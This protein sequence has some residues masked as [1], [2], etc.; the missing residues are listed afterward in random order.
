MKNI[1][2]IIV[3]FLFFGFSG[4]SSAPNSSQSTAGNLVGSAPF[5]GNFSG[6]SGDGFT[7]MVFSGNNLEIKLN[8]VSSARGKFTFS[9]NKL[10]WNLTHAYV[11]RKRSMA[12]TGVFEAMVIF[13]NRYRWIKIPGKT[14]T[15]WNYRL[16]GDNLLLSDYE[17]VATILG[18]SNSVSVSG[19][20]PPLTRGAPVADA[21]KIWARTPP[22]AITIA[23]GYK[24]YGGNVTI[25][26]TIR[27]TPVVSIGPSSFTGSGITQVQIPPNVKF[28]EL[29][30]FSLNRLIKIDIP[31]TVLLVGNK[32]FY[33]N[34]ISEVIIGKSVYVIGAEAFA[35]N[36]VRKITIKNQD[37]FISDSAFGNDFKSA[38]LEHGIGVYT[39]NS[40]VWNFEG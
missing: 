2:I 39:Y 33:K 5:E 6:I 32:S 19:A 13:E 12:Q 8:G 31:D 29:E 36:P 11:P 20:L 1:S 17:S 24:G 23:A 15:T 22:C 34:S 3:I 37:V 38:F 26:G 21:L 30:A 4:C 18:M 40:G 27:D 7:E 28:I 10:S 16:S 9:D 35:E 25:P 14:V